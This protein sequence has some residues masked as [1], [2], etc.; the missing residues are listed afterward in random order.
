[1]FFSYFPSNKQILALVETK[2]ILFTQRLKYTQVVG[3]YDEL[4]II[5][6][7]ISLYILLEG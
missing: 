4:Y 6:G 3:F 2:E 1:M 5:L 7:R